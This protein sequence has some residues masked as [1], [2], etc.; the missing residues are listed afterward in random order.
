MP[1]DPKSQL[2]EMYLEEV[3]G[4]VSPR[5]CAKTFVTDVWFIKTLI[6]KELKCTK[7]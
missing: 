7:L 6:T 2:L 4:N 1:F 3:L 5:W